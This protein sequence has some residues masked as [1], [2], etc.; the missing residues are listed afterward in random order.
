[1]KFL[2]KKDKQNIIA[3]CYGCGKQCNNVCKEQCFRDRT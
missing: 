1:M 3:Y 2:V